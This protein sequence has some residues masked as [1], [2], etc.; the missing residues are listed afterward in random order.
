MS[1]FSDKV[2]IQHRINKLKI[3]AGVASD[4]ERQGYIA[5]AAI[6][7]AQSAIDEQETLY[8]KEVEDVLGKLEETWKSLGK[9][10]DAKKIEDLTDNLYNFANNIKDMADTFKYELMGYFGQS[11]RDFCKKIDI[12]NKAHHVIIQA[13]IDVMSVAFN[14][15]IKGEGGTIAIELKKTLTQAIEKYS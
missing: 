1:N 4:D 12:K 13:H 2:K 5:D 11:L 10:Q 9:E 8:K 14:N 3:K 15:N 6:S 7:R